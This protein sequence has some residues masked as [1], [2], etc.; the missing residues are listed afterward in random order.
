MKQA[1]GS[2]VVILLLVCVQSAMAQTRPVLNADS[3][4]DQILDALDHSGNQLQDFVADVTLT[5]TDAR[6]GDSSSSA[7]KV[8]FQR[9]APGEARIRVSFDSETVGDRKMDKKVDYLLDNGWLWERDYRRKSEIKRQVLQPGQK[10]N[11]LKLGE[12]PFPLP[13]GQDKVE[14]HR[15]FDVVKVD[16]KESDP[17][18]TIHLTLTPKDG[19]QLAR[20]FSSID[21][22]VDPQSQ[23]PARIEA[24]DANETTVR[25]TDLTNLRMNEGLS[26]DAFTLPPIDDSWNRHEEPFSE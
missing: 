16:S 18:G 10:M 4:I 25:T 5:Q 14:V 21:V 3:S 7:G 15:Q 9:T 26:A 17:A 11:L 19:S 6:S 2:I 23:M 8:Y 13:I 20:K 22:W 12:G 1:L 24:V